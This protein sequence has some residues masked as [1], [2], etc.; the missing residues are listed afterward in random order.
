MVSDEQETTMLHNVKDLDGYAAEGVDGPI[1][2]VSDF[3]FDDRTW[4][5][6][7]L[8]LETGRW[9]KSRKVLISPIAFGPPDASARLL[10]IAMTKEQIRHSPDV[11]T[12]LPVS[13]QHELQYADHYGCPA[14]PGSVKQ[15]G[16][17][18]SEPVQAGYDVIG[19]IQLRRAQHAASIAKAS[20]GSEIDDPH[21]RSCRALMRYLIHAT[22]GAIGAV[23]GMLL[24][25][26]TWTIRYLIVNTSDWWLGHE[27][28]LATS[29]IDSVSW[30]KAAIDVGITRQ[31]LKN[32][33]ACDAAVPLDR[34]L[35]Q[36]LFEHHRRRGYWESERLA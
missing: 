18:H 6:R 17:D 7:Y 21:L 12:E 34:R 30:D 24:D 9:L 19:A 20:S 29:W 14:T 8:V 28:L 2:H 25:D 3:F 32:A 31:A 23:D 15:G 16:A 22:D 5:V 33:P 1:G 13:R 10:P 35:E 27:V 36:S 26:A 4:A 11:D